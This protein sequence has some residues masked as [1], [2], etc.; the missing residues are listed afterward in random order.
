MRKTL[1]KHWL[2]L[3]SPFWIEPICEPYYAEKSGRPGVNRNALFLTM[4]FFIITSS[5]RKIS[6]KR[7]KGIT[8]NTLPGQV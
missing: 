3:L 1:E 5:L 6:K 4:A 2:E 8:V 7:V